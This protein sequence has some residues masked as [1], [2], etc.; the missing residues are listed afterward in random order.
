MLGLALWAARHII[1]CSFHMLTL[2][3]KDVLDDAGLCSLL[4][5]SSL[6]LALVPLS[7][8]TSTSTCPLIAAKFTCQVLHTLLFSCTNLGLTLT[9]ALTLLVLD[10]M[11]SVASLFPIWPPSPVLPVDDPSSHTMGFSLLSLRN[12]FGQV[13]ISLPKLVVATSLASIT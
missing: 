5:A 10:P 4:H 6:P 1:P 7:V 3:H 9:K 12:K 2:A 8:P 13:C 11:L